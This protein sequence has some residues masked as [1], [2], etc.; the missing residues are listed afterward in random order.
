[1][2]TGKSWKRPAAQFGVQ[3]FRYWTPVPVA[4]GGTQFVQ[5]RLVSPS[6]ASA[7]AST[8]LA[9]R[10]SGLF[11]QSHITKGPSIG[12]GVAVLPP[13][14]GTGAD[15]DAVAGALER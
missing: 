3:S 12:I 2:S 15:D 11:A 4:P 14:A 7:Q 1:M 9:G 6:L 8:K 13:G 10:T 5:C